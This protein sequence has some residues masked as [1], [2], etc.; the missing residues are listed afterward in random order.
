MTDRMRKMAAGFRASAE[1]AAKQSRAAI[2]S[3][4]RQ[5]EAAEL[6]ARLQAE[7]RAGRIE[8]TQ[9]L[10]DALASSRSVGAKLQAAE[11]CRNR[12]KGSR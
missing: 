11:N 7:L 9:K 10:Y 2:A 5:K 1:R 4:R 12:E 8:T 3:F 6:S